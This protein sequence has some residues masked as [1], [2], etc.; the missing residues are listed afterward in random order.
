M[1]WKRI[2]F[3]LICIQ[4]SLGFAFGTTRHVPDQYPTIQDAIDA[5]INGDEVL[6]ARGTYL[7]SI[8]IMGKYITLR[9]LDGPHMTCIWGGYYPGTVV[10][11]Q[12]GWGNPATVIEGFEITSRYGPYY[13]HSYASGITCSSCSLNVVDCNVNGCYYHGIEC[14]EAFVELENTL[15]V[16]NEGDP[17]SH[18]AGIYGNTVDFTILNCTIANN[19]NQA[20]GGGICINGSLYSSTIKN[21][22]LWG[23]DS[24]HASQ[25]NQIRLMNHATLEVR[26]SDIQG[27]Q[28]DAYVESGSTLNWGGGM[29]DIDPLFI[30]LGTDF[31]LRATSPC[32]DAGDGS[33]APTNDYENDPRTNVDMGAD[34]FHL[35]LYPT[36][37]MEPDEYFFLKIV[38]PPFASPVMLVLGS[39]LED[40]PLPTKFGILHLQFPL[41]FFSYTPMPATGFIS[42]IGHTPITILPGSEFYIQAFVQG[43]LSNHMVM[44]VVDMYP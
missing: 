35:H 31:H 36:G 26:F 5:S 18:G 20:G 2:L 24:T 28:A 19:E 12:S 38:G 1:Y 16:N 23:N 8:R 43:A 30:H 9:S 41:Y 34:E 15:V 37:L 27:G 10:E 22:I 17:F 21:S 25:G 4:F 39:G 42:L 44:T 40:P 6:V 11:V 13:Y 3:G 7:E 33:G 29:I 14:Y 32:I